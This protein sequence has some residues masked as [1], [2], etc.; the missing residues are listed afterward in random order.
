MKT[1]SVS[2]PVVVGWPLVKPSMFFSGFIG[3]EDY[4]GEDS[5]AG[6]L[7]PLASRPVDWFEQRHS[8]EQSV[9]GAEEQSAD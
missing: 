5:F 8:C 9:C 7:G 3:Y 1:Q 6:A 4:L 2:P